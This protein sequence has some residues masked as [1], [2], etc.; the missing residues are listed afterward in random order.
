MEIKGVT[1]NLETVFLSF[2][3]AFCLFVFLLVLAFYGAKNLKVGLLPHHP[4][5]PD[6][7]QGAQTFHLKENFQELKMLFQLLKK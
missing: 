3:F 2:W 4:S 7:V 1:Q 5:L 6:P